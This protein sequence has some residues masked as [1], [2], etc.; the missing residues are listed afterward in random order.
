MAML[1]ALVNHGSGS[2]AAVC[3]EKC[4]IMTHFLQRE[5]SGSLKLVK[6]CNWSFGDSREN[7]FFVK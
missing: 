5:S 7:C 1:K 2:A 4:A 3:P 6:A